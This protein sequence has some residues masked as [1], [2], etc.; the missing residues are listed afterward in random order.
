[1]ERGLTGSTS[2]DSFDHFDRVEFGLFF[3]G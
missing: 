3:R 2:N 1:M